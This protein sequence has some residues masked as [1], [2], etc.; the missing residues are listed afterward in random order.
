M[1]LL[2]RLLKRNFKV[3]LRIIPMVIRKL[4][5]EYTIIHIASGGIESRGLLQGRRIGLSNKMLIAP[6][7]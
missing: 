3:C 1:F 7:C 6:L 2:R 4:I 5:G